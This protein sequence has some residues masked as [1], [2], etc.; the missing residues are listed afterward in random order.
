MT[1]S[2]QPQT[3]AEVQGVRLPHGRHPYFDLMMDVAGRI[4]M[5]MF[6]NRVSYETLADALGWT[7]DET[8]DRL[9]GDYDFSLE[10]IAKVETV[11]GAD[12]LIVTRDDRPDRRRRTSAP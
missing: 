12:V 3:P 5:A 6:D 10:E 7:L 1:H 8:A 4:Q 9:T 11:L 2:R